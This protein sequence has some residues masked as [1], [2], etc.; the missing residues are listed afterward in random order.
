[1]GYLQQDISNNSALCLTEGSR[2]IFKATEPVMLA[3]P[4][5]QNANYWR[6]NK[7]EKQYDKALFVKLRS[8]RKTIADAEDI[9]PFIVFNDKTLIELA[10]I[11]PQSEKEML[12]ISGIGDTKLQRYGRPF[13]DVIHEHQ[14]F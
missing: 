12:S 6:H 7:T 13:L 2:S 9:A 3:A 1:M 10:R 4:R 8:L 5:L 14:G 11:Q